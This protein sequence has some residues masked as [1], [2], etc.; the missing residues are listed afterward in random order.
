MW[1]TSAKATAFGYRWT[2]EKIE[3]TSSK[4]ND[5]RN[6]RKQAKEV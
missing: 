2:R 1:L 6:I 3:S 5:K 4:L